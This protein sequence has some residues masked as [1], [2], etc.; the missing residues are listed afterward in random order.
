[1]AFK[2]VGSDTSWLK[3][4]VKER[5]DHGYHIHV[6]QTVTGAVCIFAQY[7]DATVVYMD[8]SGMSLISVL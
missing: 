8:E 3:L 1:M 6:P 7:Y 4:S 2:A 5:S